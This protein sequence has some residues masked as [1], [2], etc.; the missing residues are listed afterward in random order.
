MS[1]KSVSSNSSGPDPSIPWDLVRTFLALERYRDYAIAAEMEGIDHSTLRRR[2]QALEQHLG[3]TVFIRTKRGWEVSAD[4]Q[5]LV[6][7]ARDMAEAA[8]RF[9]RAV[10]EDAGI[11]RISLLDAFAHRFANAFASFQE[12]YPRLVLNITTET[13][14]VDLIQDQ[15]D[16]AIRLARPVQRNGSLIIKKIGDVPINA[17][18][19]KNYLEAMMATCAS[20]PVEHH[21]LGMNLGFSHSDHTFTY[22]SLDRTEFGLSG[23]VI[24]WSDSF[25]ML[26]RLCENGRGIAIMPTVMAM[27]YPGLQ[28]VDSSQADVATELWMI[29]RFDLRAPW[30]LDLANVLQRELSSWMAG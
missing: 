10:Q 3:R 27:D 23:K 18:A 14:F 16:I 4:L 6:E 24:A 20:A 22:G 13:H 1:T 28:K 15:I 17:Y 11:I 19:S 8:K 26:A 5:E 30:Q 2:I 25:S 9:S 12:K 21:F 29:S 7:A